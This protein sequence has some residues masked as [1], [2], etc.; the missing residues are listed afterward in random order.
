MEQLAMT[1]TVELSQ[2]VILLELAGLDGALPAAERIDRDK[3]VIRR[4]KVMGFES[5]NTG[6]VA[7][8]N[9]AAHGEAA[10]RPYRYSPEA[11]KN[12]LPLFEGRT[13]RTD[14]R[15]F[16]YKPD[17]KREV[18]KRNRLLGETFGRLVNCTV[19]DTGIFADLE[20]LGSHPLTA[21]VLEM[22][23]R[24]PEQLALSPESLGDLQVIDGQFV[25]TNIRAVNSVDLIGERPG[26]TTSLFESEAIMDPNDP[27]AA[28]APAPTVTTTETATEDASGSEMTLDMFITK[29]TEIF[30][31]DGDAST[32]ASA[33]GKL[34]KT[35]LKVQDEIDAAVN[36]PSEDPAPT[37]SAAT[38]ESLSREVQQLRAEKDCR[39]LLES[40]GI[41]I[42]QPLVDALAA[43]PDAASRKALLDSWPKTPA[44]GTAPPR[45]AARLH[46]SAAP[47]PAQQA[48]QTIE[49]PGKGIS[50][51]RGR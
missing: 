35:L 38:M 9:P 27:A 33:I 13:V 6:R 42:A 26:T 39:L 21:T 45:S 47:D 37:D 31:G 14:H 41:P 15:E 32:K 44:P 49:T 4:V 3:K 46:E 12:A 17:G 18:S 16:S 29:A 5:R 36:G 50:L 22:A 28:T 8:F 34:A 20:Y 11:C 24:M 1:A 25:V 48:K 30:N 43:L 23:E 2:P 10:N 51:L 19:E 40:A 7:G